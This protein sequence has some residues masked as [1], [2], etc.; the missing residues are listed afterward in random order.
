MKPAY[1]IILFIVV[2]TWY[3]GIFLSPSES[4]AG[5]LVHAVYSHVCHQLPEK[6]LEVFGLGTNV[7]ARCTGIYSGALFVSLLFLL[8]TFRP[9]I[10]NRLF[11]FLLLPML[12][13]VILYRTGVYGYSKLLAFITGLLSGSAGFLY[14]LGGLENFVKCRHQNT[15]ESAT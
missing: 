13:D 12:I 11:F 2:I 1:K 9:L 7:C 15:G 8:R 6:C 4:V 14:I 5:F 3:S 10:G